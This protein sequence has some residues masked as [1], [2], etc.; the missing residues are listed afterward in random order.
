MISNAGKGN[1]FVAHY[2]W[3]VAGV[4]V[5]ALVGAIAF[6]FFGGNVEE[7][8]ADVV[9][10]IN[11]KQAAGSAV[12]ELNIADYASFTNTT[13]A[14]S[15]A[16]FVT[17]KAKTFFASARR[18]QCANEKCGRATP[19][20][21]DEK[22]NLICS[23]CGYTQEVA[24][25][26]VVVDG[27]GDGMPDAWEI[28]YGLNP[29]DPADAALD[30]DKDAFTNLEECEAKTDPTDKS[31]HPDYLDSLAVSAPLKETY[32]PFVFVAANKIPTGWRCEFYDAKQ[33]DDYG[34]LGR[35]LT[36]VIGDPIGKSGYILRNY[37]PK[38]PKRVLLKGSVN[39]KE[40]DVSEVIVERQQDGKKITLVM[41]E[42]KKAKPAAVDVQ[43]T[44]TYT[45][46]TVQ[47]FEVV[48]GTEIVLSEAKYKIVEVRPGEKGV[49][50]IQGP[51]G[52]KRT[53]ACP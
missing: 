2:D 10:R 33:K 8:V 35:T 24:K 36:A 39:K 20:R 1:P 34:R 48:T 51:D 53:L 46:G 6:C 19:E 52:K 9:G 45:R 25:A 17:S 42:N 16:T 13:K 11:A 23:I 5:L 14:K 50:V 32:M 28:K 38:P 31:S 43:A 15:R 49:V 7:E 21:Y 12:A 26:E 4:G 27:D 47:T 22:K 3:F 18:L 41:A 37:V 29:K 44:L 30:N 40:V